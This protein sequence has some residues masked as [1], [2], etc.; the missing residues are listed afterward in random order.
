VGD[1]LLRKGGCAERRAAAVSCCVLASCIALL[2]KCVTK[3]WTRGYGVLDETLSMTG[4]LGRLIRI[5][6]LKR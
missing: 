1:L 5:V 4:W 2:A 3:D 6:L